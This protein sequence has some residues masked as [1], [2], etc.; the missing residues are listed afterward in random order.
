MGPTSSRPARRASRSPSS[1]TPPTGANPAPRQ[2]RVPGHP[3]RVLDRLGAAVRQR[4]DG[5]LR[6]PAR[7]EDGRGRHEVAQD[8][9]AQ[10]PRAA[11]ERRDRGDLTD[12]NVRLAIQCAI[13]RQE[14]LDTAALG[15]GEVTGPITSPAYNSDPDSRPCPNRDLD[16]AADYLAKAGKSA[17]SR[18]RR[19]SRRA[20]TPRSVNEAQNLKAQLAEAK[21][22]L[23]LQVLESGA[24][25]DRWVAADFD[26]AVALN[27]GR[28]DPDGM[29]GRYFTSTGNL[30]KVAGYS[31]PELDALFAQGKPTSDR[32]RRAQAD[33]HADVRRSSRTTPRGSGCS[34][35]T[36]PRRHDAGTFAWASSR[37][38][39]ARC[40]TC[41]PHRAR[42][43]D[44]RSSATRLRTASARP[45]LTLLGVAVV[46]F[47]ML[48]AI[49]GNQITA[50]LGTEAAALTPAPAARRCA[51]TTGWTSRWSSSSSPGS[52]T[53]S[54]ATSASPRRT[55]PSVLD[56]RQSLPVTMEL[57]VLSIVL[58]AGDRR[59]ARDAVGEP[60]P[61]FAGRRRPG[62]RP[63][64][65][66]DPRVPPRA[67][68]S[69][70]RLAVRLQ[71]QRPRY[72]TFLE[73][74]AEPAAD[75]AAVVRARLRHRGADHAHDAHRGARG[76]LEDF[77]RTARAKGVPP[78][79]LQVRH[80]LRNA[81][82]PIVTMTGLQFGYLLG[83]AVVVEQIF[84]IP[85]IGRQVL[86]GI[87]QK[88]Y[89]LVQSTVLVIAL[90]VRHRQPAHRPALP[91]HRPAGAC[92]SARA[93]SAHVPGHVARRPAEWRS[94]CVRRR[95]HR[96]GPDGDRRLR[97]R[98][99]AARAAPYDPIAQDPPARCS[100][101]AGPL[102]RHGPVRARRVLPG[103][104]RRGQL[105]ARRDRGGDRGGARRGGP[106][107][108]AGFFRGSSTARSA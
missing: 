58:G 70:L 91:R 49:P 28:P 35:A 43:R 92:M 31:S 95:D 87:Q 82:V 51:P 23:D 104:R 13:D 21:I 96:P 79:R 3:R 66:L 52:A 24:Y 77:I 48:R 44:R 64:R 100:R 54:P 94:P 102:V 65:P 26:A 5:R 11:A 20:S 59:A 84:S 63:R 42:P 98:S 71:P 19:S 1:G 61:D 50:N 83:G 2:R 40:S 32:P 53:C 67:A 47:V 16:K 39:T 6:R 73:P 12:V 27:G 33:L 7:R 29:Y 107:V 72:A 76:A 75:A 41:A 10:L 36:P 22:N 80:V 106:R 74:G 8:A 105:A 81:L 30:N 101:R 38:R 89:A 68:L 9:A 15:E 62:R 99:L 4:P 93:D 90:A 86:L 18:S 88:E 60:S 45:L 55:Q 17:A 57:A 37:W 103:R 108:L 78:R 56:D 25:V 34:P 97:S 14:V 69:R 46:V 85:G